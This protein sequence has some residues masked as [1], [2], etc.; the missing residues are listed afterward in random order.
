MPQ[1]CRHCQRKDACRPRGLCW[2]CYYTPGVR[3][4]YLPTSKYAQRGATAD[5]RDYPLPPQ[6]T[7]AIP[8]TAEKLT[9][10]AARVA[11][12]FQPCHPDDLQLPQCND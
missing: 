11:A 6:T 8:G 3:D 2:T 12:G 10:M 7:E 5:N 9:I 1:L 4:R